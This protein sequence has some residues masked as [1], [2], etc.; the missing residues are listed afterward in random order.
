MTSKK[1]IT[2]TPESNFYALILVGLII[3]SIPT[4]P[5]NQNQMSIIKFTDG[6]TFD[7][8]GNL[9]TELRSDGWYVLGKGFLI[10]VDTEEKGNE[11]ILILKDE[12]KGTNLEEISQ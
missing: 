7:T 11:M 5:Q 10:A 1:L 2:P 3:L 12:L 4:T 6:E 9:R 8:S